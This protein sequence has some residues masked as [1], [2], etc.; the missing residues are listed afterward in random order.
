VAHELTHQWWADMLE[1]R[2]TQGEIFMLSEAM[3]TYGSLQVV[4]TIEG[5]A[6]A[7]TYRQAGYPGYGDSNLSYYLNFSASGLD[8]V[9]LTRLNDLVLAHDL[10]ATKGFRIWDMLRRE[11]GAERFR[12][13]LIAFAK[14]FA[15]KT[16]TW[17]AF[18]EAIDHAAGR[19]LGWFYRQWLTERAG[20]PEWHAT[21]AQQNDSVR[22]SIAP[23]GNPYRATVALFIAGATPADT[24]TLSLALDGSSTR[25]AQRIP[26]RAQSVTVDPHFL[27]AHW[28]Q[29]LSEQLH[30]SAPVLRVNWL[31][32][33]GHTREAFASLA[34]ALDSI[35]YPDRWAVRYQLEYSA[36]W[37]YLRDNRWSDAR[38]QMTGAL[39]LRDTPAAQSLPCRSPG[40]SCSVPWGYYLIANAARQL[41]DSTG[42]CQAVDNALAADS[43]GKWG[44]AAATQSVGSGCGPRPLQQEHTSHH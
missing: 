3:A 15:F 13:A 8:T 6:A 43:A 22:G 18:T 44:A 14:R 16:F 7:E 30:G 11:V 10:A 2:G 12:A 17:R 35:P 27:V 41:G 39:A 20:L 32:Q 34:A 19:D 23:V 24:L 42:V 21:W 25:F 5:P 40:G 28:P 38:Q 9:P 1:P 26:F 29:D 33:L 4:T 36:A 37:M 31:D